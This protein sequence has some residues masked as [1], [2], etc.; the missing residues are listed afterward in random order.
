MTK[1]KAEASV[2]PGIAGFTYLREIGT[3]GSAHVYLYEQQMPRRQVAVKVLDAGGNSGAK[4]RIESEANLMARVSTHPAILTINEVGETSDGRPFLVMEYCPPPALSAI[5][6]KDPLSVAEALNIT[7]QI[8][9]AVET[10]HR[11]G[12]VHRDIKPANILFTSYG[13]PVLSDFGISALSDPDGDSELRGMSVPWA[14]P[15]QLLGSRVPVPA[16]DIY[17]LGATAY[18]MLTCRSPYEV[19]GGDNGVYELSRRIVKAPLP[20]IVREDVPPS[21]QRVLATAMAKKPDNRYPNALAFARALQQVESELSLPIT[22]IDVLRASTSAEAQ[23]AKEDDTA[24]DT[25]GGTTRFGVYDVIDVDSNSKPRT[26]THRDAPE[27]STRHEGYEIVEHDSPGDLRL[28]G[29]RR[30]GV[31]LGVSAAVVALGA[32]VFLLNE[33]GASKTGRTNSNLSTI[34]P[35]PG[36]AVG[37]NV[38]S[39]RSL[40]GSLGAD[41]R[42]TFTWSPP[43][44]SWEGSYLYGVDRPGEQP[45]LLQA[46]QTQAVVDAE[47]VRTCLEVR[48]V[49]PNGKASQP[50]TACVDTAAQGT[51]PSSDKQRNGSSF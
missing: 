9:G 10:A 23:A 24:D 41:G 7:I 19:V 33:R 35:G 14:P 48:A 26:D 36:G 25:D 18:A 31:I 29:L 3:G 50:V 17:S 12:I 13:R 37:N 42:V 16:S 32:G 44:D 49:Q 6:E 47:P 51:A 15:E 30:L 4:A 11:A 39:P 22:T 38:P 1:P 2:P 43:T 28:P 27:D 40:K 46:N 20:Q 45:G 34:A 5:I 8:A 21:L